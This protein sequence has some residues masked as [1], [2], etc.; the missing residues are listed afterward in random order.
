MSFDALLGNEQLKENL[1]RS[2]KNGHIS[3]FRSGW[4]RKAHPCPVTGSCHSVPG[5]KQALPFLPALPQGYRGES[6]GL[7]YGGRSG[8]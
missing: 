1:T 3:H 8:A 7:H 2:L 4:R 6:S 5:G